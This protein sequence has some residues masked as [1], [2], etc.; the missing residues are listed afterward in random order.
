MAYL[1]KHP[2]SRCAD[3][4]IIKNKAVC[5]LAKTWFPFN[6]VSHLE[7]GYQHYLHNHKV[8]WWEPSLVMQGSEYGIF[9]ST[10]R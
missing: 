6:L 1:K 9:K 10:L 5:D 2:A 8:Y 4:I 7:I 3:S